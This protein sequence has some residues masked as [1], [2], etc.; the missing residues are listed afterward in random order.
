MALHG[1]LADRVP[2]TAYWQM[3]PRG[4][5][6]RRL[7]NGGMAVVE[8]V[9]LFR[10]RHPGIEAVSHEYE[11]GGSCYMRKE[12]RSP[13]GS[14][15][16]TYRRETGYDTSWW[17][18]EYFV[19][20]PRDYDVLEAYL[21]RR[22]YVADPEAFTRAA[23]RW[24][25]DGY[26]VGNTEYS[27]MNML[28]YELLGM[29]RFSLDLVD[30]PVRVLALYEIL[31]ERQ[32]RMF[33]I[34]AESPAELVLYDGNISQEVVGVDRFRR[35]YQPCHEEFAAAMHDGGK[36]AGCHFDARMATLA[37]AVG[38]S[39]LDVI[40]AF[41]PAP[42][43]DMTVAQARR[44]WP[45][46]VLWINFPSS[47]HVEGKRS[48]G[49][50]LRR[51]LRE[52]AP[53]ERLLVGITEDIPEQVLEGSLLAIGAGLRRWG[54]LPLPTDG[55]VRPVIPPESQRRLDAQCCGR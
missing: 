50:Q 8:R 24:G 33:E 4:D 25:E 29:Q 1:E 20:E 5:V 10:L 47:V 13:W 44:A 55:G 46:K 12:L 14:L 52:A 53:G 31:R 41:T 16:A 42:T 17:Q 54:K 18:Q 34:C 40:E 7:R 28:I 9:P 45:G 3:L 32:R 11:E 23:R 39:R 22:S 37:Q 21:Q 38:E 26:V 19:K 49:R 6:E 2:F 51:M 15:C 36:L 48:I 27:P 30:R 35:Y 43:C